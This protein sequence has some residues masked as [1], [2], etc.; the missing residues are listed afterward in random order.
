MTDHQRHRSPITSSSR[1]PLL[2]AAL[3]GTALSLLGMPAGYAQRRAQEEEIVPGRYR[4]HPQ[5]QM[6]TSRLVS[7]HGFDRSGLDAIFA[8][9][10]YSAT[11]ARLIMPAASPARKNWAVYRSRFVEPIRINAGRRFWKQHEATLRRAEAEYGVPPEIIVGIIGVETIYGRDTGNFRV[12]DALTTLAFDYPDTPNRDARSKMFLGQLE[13][14]LLWCRESSMDPFS[15]LGS[16]AGAIG[17]PQFMPTSIRAYATDFDADGRIDLRNSATD[18]IG[19]VARFLEMHGWERG[20]PVAW[21]IA[22]DTGSRGI[23][24]AAADGEAFPRRTLDELLKAGMQLASPVSAQEGQTPVLVVDLPSPARPVEYKIGLRNFYVLTRYN[25]SFFYAQ[26]VY[27]LG[28]AVKATN[29][30]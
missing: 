24:E 17:I 5:V 3:M 1:R 10:V 23:A 19:S 29:P 20:R 21:D 15:V 30:V 18:A 25:R 13:D 26:A 4:N 9:T 12:I 27:D 2:G 7:Q 14:F 8:S 11:V 6:F 22:S 28:Q 16:Y